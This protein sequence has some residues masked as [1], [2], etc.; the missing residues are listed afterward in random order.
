MVLDASAVAAA[1]TAFTPGAARTTMVVVTPAPLARSPSAQVTTC[2]AMVHPAGAETGVRS[3]GMVTA[4]SDATAVGGPLLVVANDT[5][6]VAPA[7]IDPGPV[8]FTCRSAT[9][10]M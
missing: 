5:S 9:S 6:P 1:D 8:A 10:V 7:A 3:A 4:S 2:P